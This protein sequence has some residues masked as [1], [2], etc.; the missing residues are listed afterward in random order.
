M[1]MCIISVLQ[2]ETSAILRTRRSEQPSC[3]EKREIHIQTLRSGVQF[4]DRTP[5]GSTSSRSNVYRGQRFIHYKAF[6]KCSVFH[7]VYCRCLFKYG[8]NLLY[9][10][11][12]VKVITY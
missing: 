4:P 2:S 12:T 7:Y 3:V 6:T 9:C 10:S 5:C 8:K 1:Y 11:D